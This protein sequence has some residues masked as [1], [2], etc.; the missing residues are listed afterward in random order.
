MINMVKG[1]GKVVKKC[2]CKLRIETTCPS[3]F[4]VEGEW[5]EQDVEA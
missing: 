2:N 3:E 5:S 4:E 1:L